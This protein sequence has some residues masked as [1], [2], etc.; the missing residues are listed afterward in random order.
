MYKRQVYSYYHK[1]KLVPGVEIIPYERYF[2]FLTNMISVFG[3]SSGSY[4][5]QDEMDALEGNDGN[6]VCLLYT[7]R[8][9]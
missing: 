3:G 1:S 7:S 4:G 2:P 9:V 5:T 8:C 6:K